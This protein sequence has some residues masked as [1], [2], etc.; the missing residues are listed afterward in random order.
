MMTSLDR[1][2]RACAGCEMLSYIVLVVL[3]M[4]IA[5]LLLVVPMFVIPILTVSVLVVFRCERI[6]EIC[7]IRFHFVI[8]AA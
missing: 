6:V 4:R 2:G 1:F 3:A 8:R 7:G 5:V